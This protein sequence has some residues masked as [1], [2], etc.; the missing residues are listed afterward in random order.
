M[1]AQ[2]DG[3]AG[4]RTGVR[5]DGRAGGRAGVQ[6]KKDAQ[7]NSVQKHVL[8]SPPSFFSDL[9]VKKTLFSKAVTP[10]DDPRAGHSGTLQEVPTVVEENMIQH[11][12]KPMKIRGHQGTLERQHERLAGEVLSKSQVTRGP[13]KS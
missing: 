4:R 6:S 7:R 1:N 13:W 3:W 12:G 10:G 9:F 11:Q 5:A 8:V 2:T